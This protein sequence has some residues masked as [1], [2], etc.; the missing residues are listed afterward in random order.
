MFNNVRYTWFM[1]EYR[2]T[3]ER[4]VLRKISREDVDYVW[5]AA[6]TPGFLDGMTWDAPKDHE[7]IHSYTDMVLADWDAGTKYPFT[8]EDKEGAFIGRI[9][10]AFHPELGKTWGLGYW[11]HPTQ[12]GHGYAT[13]AAKEVVRFTFEELKADSIVSSH[14]VWN[15]AS[16][17]VLRKI[18]MKHTGFSDDRSIKNGVPRRMA[19]FW[20][21]RKDWIK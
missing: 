21:D 18:G 4:L 11:I 8:I 6:H 16:G 5:S 10:V 7:E 12:Q 13:E 1:P 9:E 15:E 17:K 20:L 14:A 19:E 2:L 3:T